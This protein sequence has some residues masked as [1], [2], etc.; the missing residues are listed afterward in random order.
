[1]VLSD[2]EMPTVYVVGERFVGTNDSPVSTVYSDTGEGTLV[3]AFEY[4]SKN[5]E[6]SYEN[7][8]S[9]VEIVLDKSHSD[10]S[11]TT[12]NVLDVDEFEVDLT[13]N[14]RES[15]SYNNQVN[16]KAASFLQD[17]LTEG[18]V[19]ARTHYR[20]NLGT[21]LQN[22]NMVVD[23]QLASARYFNTLTDVFCTA[24]GGLNFIENDIRYQSG[25]LLGILG[26]IYTAAENLS[27]IYGD[28]YSAG[29]LSKHLVTDIGRASG[30][31][32]KH[33][34]DIYCSS[35]EAV[36]TPVEFKTRS[37]FVSGFFLN[38]DDF[39]MASGVGHVDIIDHI[40]DIDE[41]TIVITKDSLILTE[42]FIE[43]IPNGKRIFFNPLD[44]FYSETEIALSIYAESVYGEVLEE[45]FY[46]LF[47]YN[48]ELNERPLLWGAST[49]VYVQAVAS[50][51][52]VCPNVEGTSYYF[53]T[54]DHFSLNLQASI[55]AVES[56]DL[57]CSIYPQSTAFYYGKTYTVKISNVKDYHGN[58][59]PDF[60]YVF[61][62]ESP[63][64]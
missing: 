51:L 15:T 41:T 11:V 24:S 34:A 56:L 53:D 39:T 49:R 32:V 54:R 31:C 38:T 25:T 48:I 17:V 3:V 50:N 4:F 45:T 59:M 26:E 12:L 40:Y 18:A 63:K 36:V 9:D 64:V 33:P 44:D 2:H 47:G 21:V 28:L 35:L 42:V 6:N 62:I 20:I 7:I 19:D 8:L 1:M 27:H 46:L 29:F 43:D 5:T 13:V 10:D 16:L 23:I 55:N 57:M 30:K 58:V 22:N 60:E 37:L 52:A 14:M 61:T